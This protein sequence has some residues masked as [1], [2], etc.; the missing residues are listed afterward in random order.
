ML[1]FRVFDT[2]PRHEHDLANSMRAGRFCVGHGCFSRA[3]LITDR[4]H[5]HDL[6]RL[7][8]DVFGYTSDANSAFRVI[9]QVQ[10][11]VLA[12]WQEQVAN[13]L[14]V[15][16]DVRH[17]EADVFVSLLLDGREE[18]FEDEDHDTWLVNIPSHRVGL[19]RTSRTIGENAGVVAVNDGWDQL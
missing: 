1:L 16:L 15:D 14:V 11:S 8:H 2:I 10:V 19:T 17:L 9:T 5:I 4:Q 18:V 6:L 12:V 7:R 3:P 13:N